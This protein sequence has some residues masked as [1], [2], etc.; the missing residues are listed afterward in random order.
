MKTYPDAELW[1]EEGV[2]G[3]KN[4]PDL[5]LCKVGVFPGRKLRSVRVEGH[6]F[7]T[8]SHLKLHVWL[9]HRLLGERA[10]GGWETSICPLLIAL[11]S[12]HR[13]EIMAQKATTW[14]L[15]HTRYAI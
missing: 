13:L 2:V 1:R 8:R 10:G 15:F 5:P 9:R 12:K 11:P 7:A 6:P 14:K 4:R 3:K